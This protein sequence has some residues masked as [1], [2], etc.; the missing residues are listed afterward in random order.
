MDDGLMDDNNARTGQRRPPLLSLETLLSTDGFTGER[1]E[2]HEQ[3]LTPMT[4][5]ATGTFRSE[6]LFSPY[7]GDSSMMVTP[8]P[9]AGTSFPDEYSQNKKNETPSQVSA[10]DMSPSQPSNLY[11]SNRET[12]ILTQSQTLSDIQKVFDEAQKIAYLGLCYTIMYIYKTTRLKN[13][14]KALMSFE[15][16][17]VE[18]TEKMF[19]YLDVTK[20]GEYSFAQL[21]SR[22]TKVALVILHLIE[23]T[24][25]TN[26]AMH[27]VQPSDLAIT[28]IQDA[29]RS[30]K[31]FEDQEKDKIAREQ[32]AL[33]AGL[34][35]PESTASP[36]QDRPVDIR[37]TVLSH[38][39]LLSISDGLYD[40][41]SRAL[42]RQVAKHLNINWLDFVLIEST[43]AD[44]L[45]IY[46]EEEVFGH[47]EQVVGDRNKID[48][49]NRLLFAGLATLGIHYSLKLLR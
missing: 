35:L 24:M 44:Q 19:V 14:K 7:G 13:Q 4:T 22:T 2:R 34:P 23:R 10:D 31:A 3:G 8:S 47:N 48:G 32:E 33:D 29:K 11:T 25:I 9:H 26:L 42:L 37:F 18:F 17:A 30:A 20:A 5:P 1:I 49:R 6:S 28:L 40:A 12:P 16:W 36:I 15:T 46:E 45:R 39:F 43:I 21:F 41:R 27:G 38:L